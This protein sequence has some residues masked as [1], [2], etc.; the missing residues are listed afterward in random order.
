MKRYL[1]EACVDSV[2]SA[3][4][5]AENGADRLELCGNLVI[6]GTTPEG[7][8]FEL[9]RERCSTPINV[10]IRPRYGDFLYTEDEFAI[11]CRSVKNFRAMGAN[12]VVI[13]C[14]TPQ[15]DLDLERMKRLCDLA[16]DIHV[17]LHRAFDMCR[18]PEQAL[19]EAITLGCRT[20][21]TSGQKIS[22]LEG[23]ELL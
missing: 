12:G 10:L 15:G 3:V 1:L 8:L 21:L 19:E 23:I 16:G 11:I 18:E 13:G 5:A 22:C 7:P 17:T 4:A 2:E 6:G 9:I 14:L 20:I